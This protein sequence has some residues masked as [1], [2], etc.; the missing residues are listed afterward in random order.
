MNRYRALGANIAPTHVR[1]SE[2]IPAGRHYILRVNNKFCGKFRSYNAA[3]EVLRSMSGR[4]GNENGVLRNLTWTTELNL[5]R[6]KDLSRRFGIIKYYSQP[7]GASLPWRGWT[8]ITQRLFLSTPDTSFGD[9]TYAWRG[10]RAFG[11]NVNPSQ[12]NFTAAHPTGFN[13]NPANP[14]VT[15]PWH[16][17]LYESIVEDYK[18]GYRSFT[19]Y[20]PFGAYGPSTGVWMCTPI[21]WEDTFV[22]G[23]ANPETCPA[24]WKGFWEGVKQLLNGTFPAP[25]SVG[26]NRPQF[27]DPLDITI[28]FNGCN[29]YRTYRDAMNAVHTAAGGGATGD[30]AVKQLLDRFIARVVSMKPDP[31]KG[32]LS[33]IIDVASVSATPTDIHLYR[34]LASYRSD[35][36]ELADWYVITSLQ[37]AGINVYCESRAEPYRNQARIT[38]EQPPF[39][40]LGTVGSDS[41]SSFGINAGD[42]PWMVTTDKEQNPNFG[43]FTSSLDAGVTHMLQG[44]FLADE[45]KFKFG[46]RCVVFNGA[47]SRNLFIN[48][49]AS[50]NV[51]TPHYAMQYVYLVADMLQDYYWRIGN[52]DRDWYTRKIIKGFNVLHLDGYFVHGHMHNFPNGDPS[53]NGTTAGVSS[54]CRYTWWSAELN[55]MPTNWNLAS[56]QSNPATYSGDYW[57]TTTKNYFNQNIRMFSGGVLLGTSLTAWLNNIHNLINISARPPGSPGTGPFWGTDTV[58]T[59]VID[60]AMRTP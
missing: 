31:G 23:A 45:T 30:A 16:N 54:A 55:D 32:I 3:V 10:V 42:G 17:I 4:G 50:N 26:A 25:A 9:A 37:N 22:S 47:A 2:I 38:D 35:T 33:C 8:D 7:G 14:D 18:F 20:M 56:F 6:S 24:R 48:G 57:T 51:Y 5:K 43:V 34:S 40:E 44:S 41:Y 59:S 46:N 29:S 58:Y 28:Y 36:L 49:S 12:A 27:T 21:Q 1:S 53:F 13:A 11:A 19:L 39:G 52:N 60:A 15:S